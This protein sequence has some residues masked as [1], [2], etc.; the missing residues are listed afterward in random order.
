[1]HIPPKERG[2]HPGKEHAH[3]S[4]VVVVAGG[5]TPWEEEVPR[6]SQEREFCELSRD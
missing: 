2:E 5:G 4:V 6:L 1:M 3:G